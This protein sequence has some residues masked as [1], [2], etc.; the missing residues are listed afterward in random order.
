[1]V[2]I[3]SAAEQTFLTEYILTASDNSDNNVWIGAV[4]R[5]DSGSEFDWNDGSAVQRYTNWKIGHPS[6][7]TRRSCVVMQSELSRQIS[8][9]PWTD[10][11]CGGGNWFICEKLQTWSSKQLQQVLLATRRDWQHSVDELKSL[12]DNPSKSDTVHA[13]LMFY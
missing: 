6:N 1:M 10:V 2:I 7:D 9:M 8:D 4:R 5:P 3:N 11:G 13:S 12:Q